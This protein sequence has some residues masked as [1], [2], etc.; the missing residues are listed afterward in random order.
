MSF[1]Q[2]IG[3]LGRHNESLGLDRFGGTRK[4]HFSRNARECFAVRFDFSVTHVINYDRPQ[5]QIKVNSDHCRAGVTIY[6]SAI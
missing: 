3:F 5:P 6:R 1:Y 2:R 4:I